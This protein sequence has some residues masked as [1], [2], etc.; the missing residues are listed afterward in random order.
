MMLFRKTPM[1]LAPEN[2]DAI[3]A[4]RD[5]RNGTIVM[6]KVSRGRKLE[7]LAFYW[8]VVKNAADNWPGEQHMSPGVLH[9]L[10][11]MATGYGRIVQTERGELFIPDSI[12]FSKMTEDEFRQWR[13]K[14]LA[15]MAGEIGVTVEELTAYTG[16]AA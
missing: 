12:G 3:D 11:K 5:I 15:Y 7:G 1:G 9:M 2:P 10:N 16:A 4:H 14:A 13:P 8:A 6:C